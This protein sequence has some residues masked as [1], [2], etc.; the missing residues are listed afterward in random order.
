[1]ASD[2]AARQ[3]VGKAK[4]AAVIVAMISGVIA[5]EGG[6]VD[7]SAD[8]GGETNMG[9]TRRTATQSGYTGPMRTLPR[10]VA[11]SIYYDRYLVQPGYAALVPVDAAVTEELFDTT[12]NMG[13]ARPSTW[14]QQSTNALCGTRL[15]VDGR[16]GPGTIAAYHAC[17]TRRGAAALC[18]ATLDALD[19]QQSAEYV[20]LVRANPKL[21]VFLKGWLAQRISN[22]DRHKC[23]GARA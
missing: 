3:P 22:V 19:R 17:Q 11:E 9:I 12:V 1:M 2:A 8:P 20:R 13:P 16:V 5:I 10:A 21:G 7:H 15:T 18:I 6:Y 23:R 4:L 14:F